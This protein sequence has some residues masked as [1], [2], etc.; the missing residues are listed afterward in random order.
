[1]D[2]ITR[3]ARPEILAMA[4]S[5]PGRAVQP[6]RDVPTR[7]DANENPYPPFPGTVDGLPH[8]R[9]PEPQ[10][11]HLLD[12]FAE[13]FGTPRE[14]LLITRGVDEAMDLLVRAF[15]AAGRDSILVCPP[16]FGRHAV[17]ARVQSVAIHE[18]PLRGDAGF[19]LD[20]DRILDV[21]RSDPGLKVLFL[22][23]PNDPT[24]NLVRRADV[25]RLCSEL[26]GKALVVADQTY[27]EYSGDAPLSR[28][29][30]A[31]PNLVVLRTLSKE[32]SLAGEQVGVVVAHPEVVG[33]VGR[34]VI[35][36]PLTQSTIA[37]VTAA[38]TPAGIEY[39]HANIRRLL[40]ERRRVEDTLGAMPGT[41][42]HP[43]DAN[44]LLV[45]VARPQELTQ[46]MRQAGIRILDCSAVPGAGDSVRISI[47][48]YRQN[49]A[50]LAVFGAHTAF[51]G[52]TATSV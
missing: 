37:T 33:I 6:E 8:N 12:R 45:D 47:G 26:L 21:H 40:K 9:Y 36:R 41:R 52:Q 24:G 51:G 10:P 4:A 22:C 32:Y 48:T 7:L 18:V 31:H 15:C 20:V 49:D 42:V 23:T 38:V 30:D 43:S 5:G 27:V 1:M 19:E 11:G 14:R 3:L 44:F 28:D 50:M 35:P 39:A 13:C 34:I 17:S 46:S 2:E 16:V 25:L 29:I